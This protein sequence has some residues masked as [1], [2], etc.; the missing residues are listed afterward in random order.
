MN[1]TNDEVNQILAEFMGWVYCPTHSPH[2]VWLP[3]NNL[4]ERKECIQYTDSLDACVPVMEKLR[5][6]FSINHTDEIR[7]GEA[8]IPIK[9]TYRVHVSEIGYYSDIC[10]DGETVQEATAHALA[11][12]VEELKK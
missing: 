2:P 7:K 10:S 11:E 12:A 5:V 8:T 9:G 1:R 4:A 3:P 6:V